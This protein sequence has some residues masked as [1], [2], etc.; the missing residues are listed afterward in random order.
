MLGQSAAVLPALYRGY[1]VPMNQRYALL[2]D[3]MRRRRGLVDRALRLL[4]NVLVAIN[5]SEESNLWWGTKVQL[6][7]SFNTRH[8]KLI[9]DHF[10]ACL[11]MTSI[12]FR[13]CIHGHM[14][15]DA[16][17]LVLTD[18]S[19]PHRTGHCLTWALCTLR[20]C[21]HGHVGGG[22]STLIV[23]GNSK[24]EPIALNGLVYLFINKHSL[25]FDLH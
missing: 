1:T 5:L 7:C 21:M 16:H 2:I 12:T 4:S 14:A 15:G 24:L 8:W 6:N 17:L 23:P 19:N 11:A 13:L 9:I 25:R 10:W 22:S 20:L 18:Q 3:L